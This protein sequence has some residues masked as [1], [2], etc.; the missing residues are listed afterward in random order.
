[1]TII[2]QTGQRSL[3]GLGKV[4]LLLVTLLVALGSLGYALGGSYFSL[5]TVSL[6]ELALWTLGAWIALCWL[7]PTSLGNWDRLMETRAKRVLLRDPQAP[8]TS[9]LTLAKPVENRWPRRLLKHLHAHYGR[10]WRRKVR[11][12]LVFGQ[13]DEIEAIAPGL[14]A[15]HWIEG[16][17]TVLIWAGS[18][19]ADLDPAR[20][21]HIAEL[22]RW[23]PLDGVIWAVTAEQSAEHI[24]MAAGLRRLQKLSRTLR[25]ALPLH[26]WQVC[27]SAW[28]QT[29]RKTQP[30]GCLL[31]K[32]LT[33]QAL[34]SALTQLLPGLL[35]VGMQQALQK[36]ANDFCLRLSQNLQDGGIA[37]WRHTLT[38]LIEEFARGVPLRGLWFSLP[39]QRVDAEMPHHWPIDPAW[40][41]VLKDKARRA[42][43][44]GKNPLRIGYLTATTVAVIWAI[45]MLVSFTTNRT[46]V[47]QV[48][49]ALND[50]QAAEQGDRQ[51]HALNE[52]MHRLA[53]LSEHPAPWYQRFGLNTQEELLKNLWPRY[54]EAN[55]RLIRDPAAANLKAQLDALV[56]LPP[57]SP[58]RA[59]GAHTAYLQLKAYLMMANPDKA[60]ATFLAKV[61]HQN[62][63]ARQGVT[64]GV[65]QYLAPQLW[66]F[67][68]RQLPSHPEWRIEPDSPLIAQ[69]RQVLLSQ[70]GQRNGET[71]LYSRVIEQASNHYAALE[72]AQMT[73]ETDVALLFKT[74][75]TV[76]GVFTRQAW[77]EHVRPA[78]EQI[79]EARREQIDWV[80]SD[81]QADIAANLTPDALKQRLTERYF[82]DYS[83]A[84]LSFLN[85]LRWQKSN[86]LNEVI[87]QLTLMS[88]IRQSPLIALINT[89]AYQGQAGTRQQALTDS[90][91]QSA[92]SLINTDKTRAIEQNRHTPGSPLDA[93]FGPLLALV[94]KAGDANADNTLSLQSFLTRVTR[95]RLKLQQITHANDPQAMTQALAQSVF[96]GKN[97]DLTDTQSYGSLLA[98]SL[99]AEWHSVGQT[100][101][102]QPLDHAWQKVLKPSSVAL[103]NQWQRSIVDHWQ[104]AFT[105]RYPFAATDSDASLP[106]LGQMIRSDSGRI[107]QFL[108]EQLGGVLRKEGARWVVDPSYSQGLKINPR[109]LTAINQL[110]HLSDV[111]FTDGGMGIAFELSGKPVKDVVETLFILDGQKH[112]YFNQKERWQ[113]FRWPGLS[114]APG[115]RLTWIS[116]MRDDRQLYADYQGVWGLIRWME[117]AQVTPLDDGDSRFRLVITAADGSDLTWHL[118]TQMGTGPLALLELRGFSLPRE[119]FVTSAADL[120]KAGGA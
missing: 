6:R 70:L 4:Y 111:L 115:T 87:D 7:I 45:G 86:T 73:G 65:W 100:L 97:D 1:M 40:D 57:N 60:D 85:S 91:M 47:A 54:V 23:R 114:P 61:L 43:W 56:K 113:S 52:L 78:I 36:S 13:P 77:E 22:C 21:R 63:P 59:T 35:E 99:G 49:T 66:S 11:M 46:Q 120:Q 53:Y 19:A 90:L 44:V 81:S 92:Q 102:V 106:M 32:K 68:A 58:A 17:D 27:D 75:K 96:Q 84:W 101:F 67:Y 76:P 5:P 50:V 98:A 116:V 103:N 104:S 71:S 37:R 26:F 10:F 55:N 33:P 83:S 118:R 119:I 20:V 105:G 42:R 41:G 39:M 15:R 89:L 82:E 88:D 2:D 74:S 29:T 14:A 95:V 112:E 30:I 107:E 62:E 93:T 24:P 108:R 109:F 18:L 48:Q 38:P 28:P 64:P 8:S 80:L 34:E 117:Q 110:S 69:A 25:W 12:F 51:F 16:R 72:L 31:D 94:G 79:A 9:L 3:S